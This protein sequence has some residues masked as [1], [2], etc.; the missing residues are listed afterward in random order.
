VRELEK[1]IAK[2]MRK[3]AGKIAE[4]DSI[5]GDLHPRCTG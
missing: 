1:K 5:L 2:I 4:D 3:V